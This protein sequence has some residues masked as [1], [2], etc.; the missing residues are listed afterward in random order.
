MSN[1][2]LYSPYP[3]KIFIRDIDHDEMRNGFLVTSHRKKLWNVQIGLIKE[4]ERICKKYDLNWWVCGG[5][6]LGAARHKGFIPWDDDVDLAMLRPDYN[7]FLAIAANEIKYPYFLDNYFNHRLESD[8]T[9][10][11]LTSLPYINRAQENVYFRINFPSF[12]IIKIRDSRTTMIEFPDRKDAHQGI[13]IDIFPFDNVP[14]FTDDEH[15]S[16]FEV[17]REIMMATFRAEFM[18]KVISENLK[19]V[20]PYDKLKKLLKLPFRQRGIIFDN[21]MEERFFYSDKIGDI[22]Q[23]GLSPGFSFDTKDFDKTVYLPFE[24]I[25]VPA[26]VNWDN[27]LKSQYGNWHE[28]KITHK[29]VQEWSADIPYYE[30]YRTSVFMRG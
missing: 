21:F 18:R 9:P 12:P 20:L 11:P 16:A 6:L 5:T 29:H 28:M 8:E 15:T 2:E 14:P 13:W 17:T 4:F 22:R 25:E 10:D 26:P 1:N 23:F 7:K 24:E 30:Y 3:F 27:V 19:T